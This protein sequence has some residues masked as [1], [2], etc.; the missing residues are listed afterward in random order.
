MKKI[1]FSIGD[2]ACALFT[3]ISRYDDGNEVPVESLHDN[4]MIQINKYCK[5]KQ[6]DGKISN[7]VLVE[8]VSGEWKVTFPKPDYHI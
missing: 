1:V 4:I 6:I 2:E 8:W 3:N 5:D 7:P